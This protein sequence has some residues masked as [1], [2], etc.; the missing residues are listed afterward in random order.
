MGCYIYSKLHILNI[1][2][3]GFN[4]IFPGNLV[5]STIHI[6]KSKHLNATSI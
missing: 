2:D 3:F 6:P 1:Y 4:K 5:S